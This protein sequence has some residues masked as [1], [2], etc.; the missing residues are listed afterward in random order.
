LSNNNYTAFLRGINVGG[1]HKVPMV[2]L[3]KLFESLNFVQVKTFLNSGNINFESPN[4]IFVE[5]LENILE[6]AIENKFGFKVPVIVRKK[7]EILTLVNSNPFK[8]VAITSQIRLYVS[9][10]KKVPKQHLNLTSNDENA[11]FRILEITNKHICSV[12][13]LDKN[14]S[15][16]AMDIIEKFYGSQNLTTRNWNTILKVV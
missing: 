2:E 8:N 16:A 7:N 4:Q 1:H 9:F 3:K 12:L 10:F 11:A 13:D 6:T 15:I 14:S 5:E